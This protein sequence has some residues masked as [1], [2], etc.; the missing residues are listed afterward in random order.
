M[1]GVIFRQGTRADR[2]TSHLGFELC[3]A[4]T[5]ESGTCVGWGHRSA[6]RTSLVRDPGLS[7]CVEAESCVEAETCVGLERRN[8][9]GIFGQAR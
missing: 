4:E 2:R 3:G 7:G 1:R 8:G 9:S 5:Q 6:G